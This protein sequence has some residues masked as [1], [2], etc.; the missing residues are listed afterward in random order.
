MSLFDRVMRVAVGEPGRPGRAWDDLH[1]SAAV[2]KTDNAAPNT[3]KV[4]LYN[5]SAESRAIVRAGAVPA[6]GRPGLVMSVWAGYAG[7]PPDLIFTGDVRSAEETVGLDIVTDITAADGGRAYRE[8]RAGFAMAGPVT[9]RDVLRALATRM[10]LP[11]PAVPAAADALVYRRGYTFA[12]A[13][14]DAVEGVAAAMNCRWS[15]QDG[16]LVV[17]PRGVPLREDVFLLRPDSG[18]IGAPK[19][20]DDGRSVTCV[21]LLNGKVRPRDRVR[22][23]SRVINAAVLVKKVTHRA[24]MAGDDFYTELEGLIQP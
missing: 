11:D 4:T 19:L 2:E 5:L 20:A 9:G 7:T 21:S 23:E 8:A 3:A 13:L 14:R 1:M 22:L 10:G 24:D 18:L 15:I 12:G 16:Q 17:T 6:R